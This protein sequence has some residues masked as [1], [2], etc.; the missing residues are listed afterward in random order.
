M[1]SAASPSS[2]PAQLWLARPSFVLAGLAIVILVVFAELKSL[3][4]AV[5]LAGA[6]RV[7]EP[8]GRPGIPAPEPPMSWPRLRR[9]AGGR[10]EPAEVTR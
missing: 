4:I 2:T 3:A 5:G 8:C 9:L 1:A 6:L 10:R 7:R